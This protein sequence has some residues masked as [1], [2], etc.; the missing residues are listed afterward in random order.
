MPQR[1]ARSTGKACTAV[2][3]AEENCCIQAGTRRRRRHSRRPRHQGSK[4]SRWGPYQEKAAAAA[5]LEPAAVPELKSAGGCHGTQRGEGRDN[6]A[7]A[8]PRHRPAPRRRPGAGRAGPWRL[9]PRKQARA[10]G[11][12]SPPAPSQRGPAE[13]WRSAGA[14]TRGGGGERVE[15]RWGA[16]GGQVEWRWGPGGVR[17]A[18]RS[19]A[20]GARVG[21]SRAGGQMEWR[22]SAGGAL[23][24]WSWSAGGEE[25]ERRWGPGGVRVECR[26][27]A[28]AVEVELGWRSGGA[29]A[30]PGRGPGGARAE[31]S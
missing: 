22:W 31:S 20:G 30:G 8:A 13:P 25:V 28:G 17:V 6:P 16:G 12:A 3:Q 27:S 4:G 7:P 29:R 26:C 5:T 2:V 15:R 21:R 18:C 1:C 9:L 24:Q 10:P 14:R 23:V 11:G 19:S